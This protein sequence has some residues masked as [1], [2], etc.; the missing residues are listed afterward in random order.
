[1]VTFAMYNWDRFWIKRI[2]ILEH[3][4]GIFNVIFTVRC[5][6]ILSEIDRKLQ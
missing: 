2:K 4:I 3:V 6:K 5:D 1:M